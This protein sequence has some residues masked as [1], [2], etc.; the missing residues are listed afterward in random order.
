VRKL[1][2]LDF[3]IENR[4][5]AYMG[6][7]YTSGDITAIAACWVGQPSSMKVWLLRRDEPI[8]MLMGFFDW[9]V[10]A[11]MVTGHYIRKHDLPVINGALLEHGLEPLSDKLTCDTK[12]DLRDIKHLSLS[13]ENLC[14]YF[15]IRAQKQHMSNAAWREANR[16]TPKGLAMTETRVKRDVIQHMALRVRLVELDQLRAPQV[17][18]S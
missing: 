18:R 10:A 12:L 17:W 5:L 8:D 4:P 14:E 15:G 16:L 6:Q 9:F 1:R 7:D 2:I 3:D 13:Q 11:D